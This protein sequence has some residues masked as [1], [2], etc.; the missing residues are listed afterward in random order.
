[1][2][3]SGFRAWM[4]QVWWTRNCST[5][6]DDDLLVCDLAVFPTSPAANPTLRRVAPSVCLVDPI[7]SLLQ[8]EI[9]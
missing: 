8:K 9:P 5:M 2:Q 4:V 1:M 7:R 3:I 6:E